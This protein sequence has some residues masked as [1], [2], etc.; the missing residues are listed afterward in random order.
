MLLRHLFLFLVLLPL[1]ACSEPPYTNIDNQ[2]LK[3]LQAQGIPVYDIRR[4]DEWL[5]TGV[6]EGSRRLTFVDDKGRVMPDFVEKFTQAVGK[7]D[8]VILI[9]RTGSRT[10][11]LSRALVE[12]LGYTKI[13]NVKHG[14]TRWISDG[15][16][17]AKN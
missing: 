8:P 1:A 7:N 5:Q 15:L 14:I 3:T 9:C 13:Y 10:D 11:T 2:Q 6:I 4:T 12:Q 17:L 16:P